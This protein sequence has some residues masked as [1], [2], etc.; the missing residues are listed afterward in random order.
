MDIPCFVEPVPKNPVAEPVI[1]LGDVVIPTDGLL[2]PVVLYSF[3]ARYQGER[4]LPVEP[5]M[6]LR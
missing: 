3:G 1:T 6:A 5:P 2:P 4:A